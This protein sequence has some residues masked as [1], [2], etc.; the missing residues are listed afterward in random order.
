MI[1]L[2]QFHVDIIYTINKTQTP[3]SRLVSLT[4]LLYSI[5]YLDYFSVAL[6]C[7]GHYALDVQPRNLLLCMAIA[8]EH[9]LHPAGGYMQIAD[10]N[11]LRMPEPHDVDVLW[12]IYH[13]TILYT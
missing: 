9:C 10:N 6:N 2:L 13:D 11:V 1:C 12:C 8:G 3:R 7:I 5:L 4:P